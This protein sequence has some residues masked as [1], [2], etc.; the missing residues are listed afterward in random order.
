MYCS[1]PNCSGSRR[2]PSFPYL[3]IFYSFLSGRYFLAFL[4]LTEKKTRGGYIEA[5]MMFS[6]RPPSKIRCVYNRTCSR[7]PDYLQVKLGNRLAI[8]QAVCWR[9]YT[10][11]KQVHFSQLY[12][13]SVKAVR[14]VSKAFASKTQLVFGELRVILRSRALRSVY[15][16]VRDTQVGRRPTLFRD[17]PPGACMFARNPPGGR[18]YF[19][20]IPH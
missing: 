5:T 19:P 16:L 18:R 15:T 1:N 8:A 13:F 4:V 12:S 7:A 17:S 10:N 9:L 6:W 3:H 2:G 14:S 20:R 11:K